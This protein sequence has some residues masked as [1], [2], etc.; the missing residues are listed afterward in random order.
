[1]LEGQETL[2]FHPGKVPY[3]EDRVHHFVSCVLDGKKPLVAPEESLKVQ[4]VLDALYA[5]ADTGKEV[6]LG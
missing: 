3:N 5:S 1:M 6:K 2:A 4:Q